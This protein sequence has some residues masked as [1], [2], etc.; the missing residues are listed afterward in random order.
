M[1]RFLFATVVLIAACAPSDQNPNVADAGV[2]IDPAHNSRNSLDWPG[3]Y[4]GTVPCADCDGIRTTIRLGT[5]GTFE[6]ELVYLGESNVPVRDSGIFSWNDLGSVVT[7]QAERGQTQMYQVGENRLFHLDLTGKRITGDLAENYVLTK[8]PRDPRIEDRKWLLTE[9]MGQ[10]VQRSTDGRQAYILL[11]GEQAKVSGNGSC[12]SFFGTYVLEPGSRIHFN[13]DL[14]ATMM[15]CP[16][17]QIEDAF[18]DALRNVDNYSVT[19]SQLSLN[20]ARMAPLLGFE[21]AAD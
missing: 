16:D 14:G 1:K 2:V 10:P 13:S 3:S 6:R 18:I 12:N 4:S 19:G 20:R 5:G 7:L 9:V 8:A 21:L 17:M 11:H 15:A